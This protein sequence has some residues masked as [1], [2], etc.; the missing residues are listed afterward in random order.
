MKKTSF[1]FYAYIISFL[2]SCTS[3]KQSFEQ[4]DYYESVIQ[5]VEKLRKNPNHKKTQEILSQSYPLAVQ[6]LDDQIKRHQNLNEPMKNSQIVDAYIQLNRMY[7]EI[8]RSPGALQV[9]PNPNNYYSEITKY[10]R[11]AAA[12]QYGAGETLL[13]SG[14]REDAKRA[15][16]FFIQAN[17]YFP[18]YLDVD[19]KIREAQYVA[20]LKVRVE[21]LH[22]PTVQYDLSIRFFQDRVEQLFFNYNQNP[23]VRFYASDDP[24]LKNPDQILIV[25]FDD[26]MVGQTNN[27][28]K[29]YELKKDSVVV[30]NVKLENG[31]TVDV[32]GT[33]KARYIE[34]KRE[35][36]SEGLLSMKVVDAY[37]NTVVLHEKFPGRFVWSTMWGSFNGDEKAL[38]KKQLEISNM[39]PVMPPPPQSL[40]IEFCKPIYSQLERKIYDYYKHM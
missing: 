22:P 17:T 37:S 24:S 28:Q 7:D 27:Y 10:Q 38:N 16:Q 23:F 3:A 21:Q 32:Y 12:E 4:G 9:V 30:G 34:N 25:Q 1:I 35:V 18:G 39:Q 31:K 33:A 11:L 29:T 15:Y 20:T 14:N 19:D 5:S 2:L 36:I 6:Y 26:F 40:F 13:K 8:K